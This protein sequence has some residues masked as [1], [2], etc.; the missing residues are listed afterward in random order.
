MEF[1]SKERLIRPWLSGFLVTELKTLHQQL[2]TC[3]AASQSHRLDS[4]LGNNHHHNA[5][6][7]SRLDTLHTL[8]EWSDCKNNVQI[9]NII[10]CPSQNN[11]NAAHCL[12]IAD[13][14]VTIQASLSENLI[15]RYQD[16]YGPEFLLQFRGGL[17]TLR[18]YKLQFSMKHLHI[19]PSIYIDD[20]I[21]IGSEGSPPMFT[22]TISPSN[23]PDIKILLSVLSQPITESSSTRL[24]TKL[25][26]SASTPLVTVSEKSV[27][28]LDS[29]RKSSSQSES[30]KSSGS[31]VPMQPKQTQSKLLP[32]VA[33]FKSL[34][35]I[36]NDPESVDLCKHPQQHAQ[37]LINT[38]SLPVASIPQLFELSDQDIGISSD[39]GLLIDAIEPKNYPMPV[40]EQTLLLA[41]SGANIKADSTVSAL[42]MLCFIAEECQ[43]DTGFTKSQL[44]SHHTSAQPI[45]P[46]NHHQ[47]CFQSQSVLQSPDIMS[48]DGPNSVNNVKSALHTRPLTSSI[49]LHKGIQPPCVDHAVAS[50]S[51]VKCHDYESDTTK[52]RLDTKSTPLVSFNRLVDS[53]SI[54]ENDDLGFE[55][56]DLPME[57]YSGSDGSS[58]G[59]SAEPLSQNTVKLS[60]TKNQFPDRHILDPTSSLTGTPVTS[61]KVETD[62]AATTVNDSEKELASR[63]VNELSLETSKDKSFDHDQDITMTDSLLDKHI[64]T[65]VVT[66]KALLINNKMQNTLRSLDEDKGSVSNSVSTTTSM[67]K[68]GVDILSNKTHVS[69]CASYISLSQPMP[70]AVKLCSTSKMSSSQDNT[71]LNPA[72]SVQMLKDTS[73][74]KPIKRSTSLP[75]H[76]HL[77]VEKI[78]TMP[79]TTFQTSQSATVA[80]V[81]ETQACSEAIS[82]AKSPST[83]VDET[84]QSKYALNML[85]MDVENLAEIRHVSNDFQ[86]PTS[87]TDTIKTGI[88]QNF[89]TIE[90]GLS[91]G[92]SLQQDT[93]KLPS[94]PIQSSIIQPES[95]L[96]YLTD[97][98]DCMSSLISTETVGNMASN[99]A[100][101]HLPT[102]LTNDLHDSFNTQNSHIS[103]NRVVSPNKHGDTMHRD[104]NHG[105]FDV[106]DISNVMGDDDDD[107]IFHS[108][109]MKEPQKR[110]PD[111]LACSKTD[112]ADDYNVEDG[113]VVTDYDLCSIRLDSPATKEFS[114]TVKVT[115]DRHSNSDDE[116]SIADYSESNKI[117]EKYDNEPLTINA[118]M[119]T[120]SDDSSS[121]T[122]RESYSDKNDKKS[123]V[124][125]IS[126]SWNSPLSPDLAQ[127]QSSRQSTESSHNA[128]A[129]YTPSSD[130]CSI[131]AELLSQSLDSN[132]LV[133]SDNEEMSEKD[134]FESDKLARAAMQDITPLISK[135]A[136]SVKV[137]QVSDKRVP[138]KSMRGTLNTIRRHSAGAS[139]PMLTQYVKP[140]DCH[141]LIPASGIPRPKVP[142]P[143]VLANHPV[144]GSNSNLEKL[145]Q[146]LRSSKGPSIRDRLIT[147]YSKAA[148]SS[149]SSV[150]GASLIKNIA[151]TTQSDGQN[152]TR[153][154]QKIADAVVAPA[155]E[156]AQNVASSLTHASTVKSIKSAPTL[157]RSIAKRS[158]K[159]FKTAL[160]MHDSSPS[161]Q[162]PFAGPSASGFKRR[163]SENTPTI[164]SSQSIAY[165][166]RYSHLRRQTS[167]IAGSGSA[168]GTTPTR[169]IKQTGLSSMTCSMKDKDRSTRP[170]KT[171]KTSRSG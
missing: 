66:D 77:I 121:S 137:N 100:C 85:S 128:T 73:N 3:A 160:L 157:R 136:C 166:M 63:N 110:H 155:A 135:T 168:L 56:T 10:S 48:S 114:D 65:S 161:S 162:S 76:T 7:Q 2:P 90:A 58:I 53:V 91:E 127:S 36:A 47:N 12:E 101:V 107:Y 8:S 43:N 24:S 141:K 116:R 99:T 89:K 6:V 68:N 11:S 37:G 62:L 87:I 27:S 19:I 52:S 44:L 28:C 154:I 124:D 149:P 45:G 132:E 18:R 169:N 55:I 4:A 97:S 143:K 134:A 138:L 75:M 30:I 13:Q 67:L 126:N 40:S 81:S 54:D 94:S 17:S 50:T 118:M 115:I 51:T 98:M 170:T 25:C 163:L 109:G 61:L 119:S 144:L 148:S 23:H 78:Q 39:Q 152:N 130:V 156:S 102:S 105:F 103:P 80:L 150:T 111:S 140:I 95:K 92:T 120:I 96:S 131:E 113:V 14:G 83:V 29:S 108:P 31:N 86:T 21:I 106:N 125:D 129:V 142:L 32:V 167:P 146:Q 112:H 79:L 139:G 60:L 123:C 38:T 34:K 64:D 70:S 165:S 15:A 71:L 49:Q 133:D 72:F 16:T 159:N 82:V 9:V 59:V 5:S 151:F 74:L 122:S 147:S 69:S 42:N 35:E 153:R 20:W 171:L 164:N 88:A 46:S 158:T 93:C 26:K 22:N 41:L 145:R 1:H 57:L 104:G 117:S 84:A 33:A